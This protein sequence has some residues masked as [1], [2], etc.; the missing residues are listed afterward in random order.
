MV[1]KKIALAITFSPNFSPLINEAN[2]LKNLFGS[3]LLFIHVGKMVDED[4]KKLDTITNEVGLNKNEYKVVCKE[5][6]IEDVI[7]DVCRNENVDLLI[8]GALVKEKGLKYY[9]GSVSR[10]LMRSAPCSVLFFVN[11]STKRVA[12]NNICV[13]VDFSEQCEFTVKKAYQ[14]AKLENATKFSLIREFQIPGLATTIY[15]SGSKEEAEELRE[16]WLEEEKQKVK[17]FINELNLTGIDS[18]VVCLYG[19]QGW[20]A[21]HWVSQNNGDLFVVSSP[22][23][24]LKLLD[25]IFQHDQEFIFK[26]LPCALLVV[27]EESN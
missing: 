6:N 7:I 25:R 22:Q 16:K 26:Q 10:S 4:F 20:E 8:A 18:Q 14:I 23:K 21:S 12:F 11:P 2:R 27:K 1:F 24:K 9:L 19:K 17:I 15:D 3:E 5:G 13:T